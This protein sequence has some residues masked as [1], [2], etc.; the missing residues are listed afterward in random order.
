VVAIIEADV[1]GT[2]EMVSL[3]FELK[4]MIR[5]TLLDAAPIEREKS[6]LWAEIV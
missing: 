6:C 3:L 5:L 1:A 4:V 2:S